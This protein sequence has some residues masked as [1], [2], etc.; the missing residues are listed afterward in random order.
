MSLLASEYLQIPTADLSSKKNTSCNTNKKLA[1][2]KTKN[3]NKNCQTAISRG[4][5]W[6]WG[7]VI[8]TRYSVCSHYPLKSTKMTLKLVTCIDPQI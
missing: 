5:C 6:G 2:Y 4:T 8:L 7:W 3:A 1:S